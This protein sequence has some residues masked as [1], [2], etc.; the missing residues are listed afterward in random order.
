MR[1]RLHIKGKY[2][3]SSCALVLL[4]LVFTFCH[5]KISSV[6][7]PSTAVVGD[8]INIDVAVDISTNFFGDAVHTGNVLVA[9][10]MPK[11]WKG[12]QNMTAT[13][14]SSKGNGNMVFTPLSTIAPN[15][16]GLTWVAALKAKFQTAGNLIDDVEW[17]VMQTDAPLKWQNG[18]KILGHCI[19]KL[20]VA[21]DQNP[22]VVKLGYFVAN[23][24]DGMS[25]NA[26]VADGAPYGP[27]AV[28]FNEYVSDCFTVT[29][30]TGD[31]VDFC[32]AQLTTIDPPKSLDNDFITLAYNNAV[33]NSTVLDNE[34]EVYLCATATTSD[35]KTITVC[36]QTDKTKLTQTGA[37]TGLYKL[38][39]WPR[40]FFGATDAQTIISMTYYITNK[41]GDKKVGYGNTSD[42]F[43]FKFKC[44]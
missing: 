33:V 8:V 23:S 41:A 19:I 3:W 11:G 9:V 17:V 20:K 25:E 6:T 30:G 2:L 5:T 18:D 13:Y 44:T 35:G 42:P 21:A 36:E 14:T 32:N 15:S 31:L 40:K 37:K 26:G 22:T 43:T 4:A 38:T 39:F 7:M 27:N 29:G 16:G 24:E 34:P 12:N 1:T 28:Y 10:L